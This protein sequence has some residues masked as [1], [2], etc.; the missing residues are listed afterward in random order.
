MY[1]TVKKDP[2]LGMY[3]IMPSSSRGMY[4]AVMCTKYSRLSSPASLPP[5][6]PFTKKQES[7]IFYLGR[8][9]LSF[10]IRYKV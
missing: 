8:Q 4:S 5:A 6:A 7:Y 10:F 2:C 9:T 3:V 1:L